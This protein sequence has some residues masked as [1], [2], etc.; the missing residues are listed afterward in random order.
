MSLPPTSYPRPTL[1][2]SVAILFMSMIMSTISMM[3]S[4]SSSSGSGSGSGSG[5]SRG[6]GPPCRPSRARP[7][8]G[9]RPAGR[10]DFE[11]NR[12]GQTY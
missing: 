3:C 10:P 4:S 5:S 8:P 9:K 12:W 11:S 1:I 6:G 2:I 7:L